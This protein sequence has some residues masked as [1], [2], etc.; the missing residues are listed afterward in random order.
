MTL[1]KIGR[2]EILSELGRGG[3]ST[4]F[5][6]HDPRF[7]RDVA[8][9]LLPRAFLHDPTF[10][11]RF[12]REAKTIASL[13][14]GAIVPVYDFG[15]EDGQPY[16]VMRHMVGGSL[17]DRMEE[18]PLSLDE[19][20]NIIS[21]LASALDEA[22]ERGIIHRDIKPGNILF[23]HRG[24]AFLTDFGIVKLTQETTTYTGGGIIGTPAYMSPE[25]ARGDR[26]LDQRSDIYALGVVL[27][28]MLCGKPPY[29]ADTPIAVAIK[30]ITE[31]IPNILDTRP[32]LQPNFV[33]LIERV[34]SKDREG[35]QATAG[36]L[37]VE[38]KRTIAIDKVV[39]TPEEISAVEEDVVAPEEIDIIEE[40]VVTFEE[41]LVEEK[42]TLPA[43]DVIAE[44]KEIIEPTE[45]EEEKKEPVP[46]APIALELEVSEPEI[47][48]TVVEPEIAEPEMP[49][50]DVRPK[51]PPVVKEKRFKVPIWGWVGGGVIII[52]I[53]VIG[54]LT[55]GRDLFTALPVSQP[56]VTP[57]PTIPPATPLPPE[58]PKPVP[59]E[60][61]PPVE[62]PNPSYRVGAFYYPWYS[63]PEHHEHWVHWGDGDFN[64]PL[65]ISSDYYPLL[66]PYSSFDPLAVAHHFDW[67]RR[68]GV[69]VV[70]TSWW[71]Q[72]SLEDEAVLLLLEMA[73]R[74]GLKVA[75][76]IEPYGGR[77]TGRVVD[78]IEYL[79]RRYGEH[80]A[81]FRTPAQ[82]RWSHDDRP[83]GLFFIW[84]IYHPNP[85]EEPVEP[86]EWLDAIEA[87]HAMPDGG[88]VI[89]NT[90]DISWIDRGHFDG[91]YNY[92]TLHVEPSS[93]NW[94]QN[95]PQQ[96]WYVPSVL[97]GFSAKRIGY[98]PS[99]FVDRRGG[100]TYEEQWTAALGVGVEPQM[101]TITSFNEWH[102]GTQIEPAI[103]GIKN[104]KGYTYADYGDLGPEGYLG[105]TRELLQ[106]FLE[107]E[108]PPRYRAQIRM[109]T[110][111]DWTVFKIVSGASW[112][113]PSIVIASD[114]A[115]VAEVFDGNILLQQPIQRAEEGDAVELVIEILFT[116]MN[117]DG[118][119]TLRIERGNIGWT[120]VELF[121]FQGE[122]PI[123]IET[124]HWGEISGGGRNMF[125]F[126]IPAAE[127]VAHL[128]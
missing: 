51:P 57:R 46:E 56:S 82:S 68:A 103:M 116:N 110:T 104:Q 111:S 52:G 98:P 2:Y 100:A 107:T 7:E 119:L 48:E 121:N 97:P 106:V 64:P 16:L 102:E 63:N 81:F 8:V 90:T 50:V 65:D 93:F 67:L 69:G 92:A 105:L 10:I 66:G 17:I 54:L 87:I 72:G 49:V 28:E 95:I 108:W 83:K 18:G 73:E 21:R 71:G 75:F 47:D 25:Q 114:E 77:S 70:I 34:L 94:A 53:V 59:T 31:P 12:S 22:H 61:F 117:P 91:I 96:A 35:R 74:Y 29:D 23:D 42:R 126:Q 44:E 36:E 41:I 86:E 40:E 38:L 109:V 20:S 122:E 60:P 84:N 1:R 14:H 39:P 115:E 27:F 19:I 113:R 58:E 76:H 127:F 101:I 128:P 3:M 99:D 120:E 118:T 26:E 112:I 79:Y 11:A 88:L 33:T 6:A 124:H 24:D 5:L 62:G 123:L 80:P 32:D 43:E 13:E 85:D 15:E 37:A 89:A 125:T 9:K 4:V 55:A 45:V 78:D 30:H